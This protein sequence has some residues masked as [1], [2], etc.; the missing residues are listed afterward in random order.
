MRILGALLLVLLM[1]AAGAAGMDED[2]MAARD[3]YRTG[4][5]AKL[6]GYAR[7]LK[8]YV[9]EPYVAY[10]QINLR[11][12]RATPAEVRGFLAAYR[13]TSVAERLRTDWVRLLGR[14][15]QWDL[16]DEELPQV[17]GDDLEIACYALQ[18][19]VR[20]NPADALRDARALWFTAR[21]VTE[22][23]APLYGTLVANGQLSVDDVWNRMRLALEAGQVTVARRVAVWL[24]APQAPD[25]KLIESATSNPAGFLENKQLA[26]HFKSRAGRESVMFATHRL[27]RSSPQQAARHW[28]RLEEN[29]AAED[30]AYVWGMIAYLGAMR[31]DADALGWYARA[32]DLSDL[33][34][35]WKVRAALRAREWKEVLA[36]IDAMTTKE[37]SDPAWR[38]WKARA[39]KATGRDGD[40]DALLKP[41]AQ[42]FS[43]YG[44]LALE[45]I[46][47]SNT[48]PAPVFKPSAE[49][50][51]ALGQVAGLRRALELYRLGLRVEGNREWLWTIRRFDDRQLITAA[52]IARR[53]ELYDR[54][55][56]TA[57]RTTDQHDFSLRYLAPYRES[58]KQYAEQLNLDEAWVFGLIRQESRFIADAKSRAG[59]SGLM[60]LMPATAQWVAKKLGLKNWRW[61]QVTEIETNVSLGTWYLRHVL[62]VL[63]G[64]PVLASA[65]YNA[66]PGRARAW[67]PGTSIEGAMY[68]ET[69][70][71]NETRDYVKKVMANAT[72]YAHTLGQKPVALKQ[73]LNTIGPRVREREPGLGDTP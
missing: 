11:L 23:C 61:T 15:Q 66:G 22:S 29:F 9:L 35:A 45:E 33:Q 19:R 67:R 42:E 49:D 69:I 52:E 14:T 3:A 56:A 60:Q 31:H 64:Q 43:F 68:A 58:V 20:G 51:R 72:Y 25:F 50:V 37:G 4:Q 62:D 18:S 41:L 57:D 13:D 12:E 48:P 73:R 44:Q 28:S 10:W 54:A 5:T 34:L 36:A 30:R 40:G 55:I 17:T 71:F 65:A 1:P 59:A 32:A 27:A 16:F 8:G 39:L 70:P 53:N 46:G 21:D 2:F 26:Q 47:G 6:E 63:D 24:P 38:Y 7:R